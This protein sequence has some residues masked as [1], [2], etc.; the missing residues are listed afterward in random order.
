[1]KQTPCDRQEFR[2]V[3]DNGPQQQVEPSEATEY[4]TGPKTVS[5][6]TAKKT[7]PSMGRGRGFILKENEETELC[8]SRSGT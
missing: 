5:H 2:D 3:G 1:M 8:L 4:Q 6:Q 7:V